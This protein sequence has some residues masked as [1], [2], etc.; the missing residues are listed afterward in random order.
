MVREAV[1]WIRSVDVIPA[2]K[3]H[4]SNPRPEARDAGRRRVANRSN[5]ARTRQSR[6]T[7][8]PRWLAL[9][10]PSPAATA[11]M[12]TQHV[13]TEIIPRTNYDWT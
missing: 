13:K 5:I 10:A 1:R 2:R 7:T 9:V 8:R 4:V 12:E 3:P 6:P 11:Q